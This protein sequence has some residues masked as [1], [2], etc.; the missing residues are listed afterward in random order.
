ML[1][2]KEQ[3]NYSTEIN[4]AITDNN[5]Y[6]KCPKC[7]CEHKVNIQELLSDN[8]VDIASSTEYCEKCSK[9]LVSAYEQV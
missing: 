4:I 7:G 5:V 3:I 2:V 8:D 9:N 6:T 1:Y